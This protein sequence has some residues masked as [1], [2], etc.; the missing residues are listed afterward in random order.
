MEEWLYGCS[1]VVTLP[2][3]YRKCQIDLSPPPERVR[4]TPAFFSV[5]LS[6]CL[7][8]LEMLLTNVDVFFRTGVLCGHQELI[9]FFV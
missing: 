2:F 1:V 5:C 9:I 4:L 6:I 8:K 7:K 3:S